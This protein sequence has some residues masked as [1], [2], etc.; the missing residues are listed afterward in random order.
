MRKKV[1]EGAGSIIG[2]VDANGYLTYGIRNVA[3]GGNWFVVQLDSV[4]VT[5]KPV[6]SSGIS[7]A[8]ILTDN[9][10]TGNQLIR[11]KLILYNHG[12][13]YNAIGQRITNP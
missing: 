6:S 13:A 2:T 8:V 5:D 3:D 1:S 9:A 10:P 4:S 12:R 7:T 11:N